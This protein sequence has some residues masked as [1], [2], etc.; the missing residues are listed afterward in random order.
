MGRWTTNNLEI[1][2]FEKII[3]IMLF[4]GMFVEIVLI[5]HTKIN[6]QIIGCKVVNDFYENKNINDLHCKAELHILTTNGKT[7]II[8]FFDILSISKGI[9][10]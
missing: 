5:N 2:F 8:D 4:Y 1:Q 3:S 7:V 6:C 9:K 10:F